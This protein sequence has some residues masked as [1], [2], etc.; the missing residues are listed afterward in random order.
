MTDRY[1]M[2]GQLQQG[3]HFLFSRIARKTGPR[4]FVVEY[5]CK[6]CCQ[7]WGVRFAEFDAHVPIEAIA[8]VSLQKL[9][10][11]VEHGSPPCPHIEAFLAGFEAKG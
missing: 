7:Q 3:R 10:H 1:S 6:D 2:I 8:A 4:E 9:L 5:R 11:S